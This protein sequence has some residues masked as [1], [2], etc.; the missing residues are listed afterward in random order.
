MAWPVHEPAPTDYW[1]SALPADTPLKTLVRLAKSDKRIEHDYRE[2]E[3]GLGLDRFE[4]RSCSDHHRHLTPVT[5]AQL[6]SPESG[7]PP[8]KTAS[9]H[10]AATA[11]LRNAESKREGA[12]L[13]AAVRTVVA[14]AVDTTRGAAWRLRVRPVEPDLDNPS[15][16]MPVLQQ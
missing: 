1:I 15:E 4:G 9:F 8:Q 2:L 10:G 6:F 7:S 5:A 13:P 16:G 3:N 11:T 14:W 12:A